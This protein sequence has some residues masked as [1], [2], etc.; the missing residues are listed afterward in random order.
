MFDTTTVG[1]IIFFLVSSAFGHILLHKVIRTP[2]Q[3]ERP[4]KPTPAAG[5]AIDKTAAR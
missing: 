2:A 4:A 1:I 5:G 3:Y